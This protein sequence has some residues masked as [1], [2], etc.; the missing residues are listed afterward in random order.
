MRFH[1]LGL[2]PIG[3]LF[4]HNLRRALSP[5]HA[6]HLMFRTNQ[7]AAAARN[8]PILIERDG[9]VSAS[10]GYQAEATDDFQ[11]QFNNF[12]FN[13]SGNVILPSRERRIPVE[14]GQTPVVEPTDKDARR[15][16]SLFVTC[17][18]YA[19]VSVL[20][21][22]QQR[23][24]S[25][26]TIVLLQNGNINVYEQLISE[27]FK[28]SNDRPHFVLASI[29]HG[30]WIKAPLHV[31]H[32]GVGSLRFAIA[33]DGRR[34][35]EKSYWDAT[36]GVDTPTL[37]LDDIHNPEEDTEDSLYWSLRNTIAALQGV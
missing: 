15:I 33:P 7:K 8:K 6:I 26:S 23:L 2:G 18:A 28:N 31:V 36:V 29:N 37:K 27:V 14:L 19:T 35:F 3:A 4:A 17:K 16:D 9:V 12:V 32:A 25:S 21:K 30:A 13:K 34:N 1:V 10:T 22:L 24:S 5:N 20:E 11:Q